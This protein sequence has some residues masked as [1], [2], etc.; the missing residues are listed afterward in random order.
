MKKN[1]IFK[2]DKIFLLFAVCIIILII[3]IGITSIYTKNRLSSYK[4]DLNKAVCAA[5]GGIEDSSQ[6]IEAIK[7]LKNMEKLDIS[8]GQKELQKYGIDA[9]NTVVI[10]DVEKGINNVYNTYCIILICF[11]AVILIIFFIYLLYKE[12]KINN[13]FNHLKNIENGDYTLYLKD[14]SEGELSHLEDEIYKITVMLKEA[15]D[16]SKKSKEELAISLSDISHQLKTQLTSIT[17]MVDILKNSKGL[18]EEKRN[19]FIN[20]IAYQLENVNR[21]VISLLKLSKIDSGTIIMTKRKTNL[22]EVLNASKLNLE[23]MCEVRNQSID[24][25]CDN[26]I[27]VL[28]DELWIREAII[29][30]IKNCLE[31][32]QDYRKVT[33][34]VKDNSLYTEI[35]IKDEGEGISK[36]DLP[37]I[38]N[39]FY[40]AKNSKSDSIGIG[41]C[42]SKSIIEKNNGDIRVE[43]KQGIG[44]TFSIKIYK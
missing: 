24:I 9:E 2:K 21:M 10:Q 17:I 22:L 4:N 13:I 27:L 31:H 14:S 1:N 43:S 3:F 41:L 29:N 25:N 7:A 6:R 8:N 30:I 18:N 39:R 42:L 34:D 19:E 26:D 16:N 33:I 37:Y 12:R 38:F 20:D 44:S 11:L 36:D 23:V 40:K 15:A 28:V 5:I 35:L 32:S